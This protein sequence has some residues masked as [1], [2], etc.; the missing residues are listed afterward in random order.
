MPSNRRRLSRGIFE[1]AF[2]VSVIYHVGGKPKETRFPPGTPLERLKRWRATHYLHVIPTR[3]AAVSAKLSGRF[4][5]VAF[6]AA[7][8]N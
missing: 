6:R 5:R 3:D 7:T 4:D 1:D 2:G 8:T